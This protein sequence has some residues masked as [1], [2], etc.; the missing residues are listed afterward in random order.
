MRV[1]CWKSGS[2]ASN[3]M[4]ETKRITS[5]DRL[6]ASGP[7]KRSAEVAAMRNPKTIALG[8]PIGRQFH[9][10]RRHEVMPR[11]AMKRPQPSIE[12]GKDQF[13]SSRP[14]DECQIASKIPA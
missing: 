5:G 3:G 13:V 11:N 2:A 1:V 6:F 10:E 9:N 14:K 8:Q 4:R 7:A 12:C